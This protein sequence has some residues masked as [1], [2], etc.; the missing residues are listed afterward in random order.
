MKYSL[1]T[2]EHFS[3][4]GASIW[5]QHCE[6]P[7]SLSSLP[8]SSPP[9]PSL[10]VEVGPLN[11]ARGFWGSAVSF[12]SVVWGEAPAANDFGAFSGWRNAAG[13]MQD[14]RFETSKT[15]FLYVFMKKFYKS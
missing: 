2:S 10:P 3:Q 1:F 7:K 8:L 13:G 11:P 4:T 5:L 12:P 6:C 9:I 14:A 15:A